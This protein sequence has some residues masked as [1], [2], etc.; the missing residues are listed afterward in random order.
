MT[1]LKSNKWFCVINTAGDRVPVLENFT[2]LNGFTDIIAWFGICH[3]SD[4]KED[5]T[6]KTIHY[7]VGL[8][9][10]HAVDK[11]YVITYF[12]T[13]LGC[14]ENIISVQSMLSLYHCI[15]YC[16]HLDNPEKKQYNSENLRT[17]IPYIVNRAITGLNI[18][19]DY[20]VEM[21]DITTYDINKYLDTF[22]T[23]REYKIYRTIILDLTRAAGFLGVR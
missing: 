17:N 12:T 6:Y 2:K 21:L 7:H 9:F 19:K 22:V 14:D 5:D 13:L 1:E 4:K 18:S 15:R 20:L 3:D 23:M 11:N 10:S 16:L 8:V